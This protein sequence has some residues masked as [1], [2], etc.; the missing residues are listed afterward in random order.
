MNR[1]K[2]SLCGARA[3]H[4]RLERRAAHGAPGGLPRRGRQVRR[5]GARVARRPAVLVEVLGVAHGVAALDAA[6]RH[7]VLALELGG[8]PGAPAAALAPPHHVPLALL[9]LAEALA[10]GERLG[11]L[12]AAGV[13]RAVV[14]GRVGGLRARVHVLVVVAVL[15]LGVVGG[16]RRGA[17][18]VRG[19]RGR[20]RPARVGLVRGR[21]RGA[22]PRRLEQVGAGRAGGAG[23]ARG[24][25]AAHGARVGRRRAGLG[26]VVVL[27][28]V[29][30]GDA[31]V[32]QRRRV[33]ERA[34]LLVE[35]ARQ[36]RHQVAGPCGETGR[37]YD[38]D[39]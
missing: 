26:L 5:G 30:V 13:A 12:Q 15:L 23:R 29:G 32:V 20:R 24:R 17:R 19:A 6:L 34:Q 31:A 3:L 28:L 14:V 27:A 8:A 35:R 21:G 16:R 22:Q 25:G 18:G 33:V 11:A 1:I 36:G 37:Y 7:A 38:V 9:Q 2:G 39:G 4:V 10:L